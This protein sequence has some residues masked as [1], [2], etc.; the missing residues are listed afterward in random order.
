M[1]KVLLGWLSVWCAASGCTS[2]RQLGPNASSVREEIRRGNVEAGDKIDV[3]TTAG[4]TYK[5]TVIAVDSTH[6]KGKARKFRGGGERVRE[7]P[8]VIPI[9]EVVRA[10]KRMVSKARTGS[11]L[12]SPV[13]AFAVLILILAATWDPEGGSLIHDRA[14]QP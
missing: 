8:I 14:E 1:R 5:I 6:I 13:L 4:V 3:L 12:A 9:D 2:M 7:N 10:K 11:L